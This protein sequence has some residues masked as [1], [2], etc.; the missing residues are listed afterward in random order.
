MRCFT[1][2]SI[3]QVHFE[4]YGKRGV[5]R[6]IGL[7]CEVGGTEL[8]TSPR[9]QAPQTKSMSFLLYRSCWRNLDSVLKSAVDMSAAQIIAR[10]RT[11]QSLVSLVTGGGEAWNPSPVEC[12]R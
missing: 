5:K 10:R 12:R 9:A 6:S 2:M 8:Y 4:Q 11:C 7:I 3:G 1:V